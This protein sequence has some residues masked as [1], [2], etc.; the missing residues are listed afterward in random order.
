MKI[1]LGNAFAAG[2][3][4]S[5]GVIAAI[6]VCA[7]LGSLL[8]ADITEGQVTR[9]CEGHGGVQETKNLDWIASQVGQISIVCKDGNYKILRGSDD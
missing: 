8:D 4:L 5:F 7:V 1:N 3:F 2:F 6:A 9:A